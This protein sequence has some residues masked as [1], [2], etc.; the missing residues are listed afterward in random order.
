MTVSTMRKGGNALRGKRSAMIP[1]REGP[2]A[3]P[4]PMAAIWMPMVF[5]SMD[6]LRHGR[7]F[8]RVGPRGLEQ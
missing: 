8:P 1:V 7:L 5:G 2:T 3:P 6:V 4:F